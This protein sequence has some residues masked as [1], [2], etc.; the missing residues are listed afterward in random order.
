MAEIR[1]WYEGLGY[2]YSYVE[3]PPFKSALGRVRLQ[4][5]PEGT[6]VQWTL[7]YEIGGVLGGVRGALGVA[8]TASMTCTSWS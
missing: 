6:V 8:R 4:E 3:R 2:E 1:A 7:E 5:I